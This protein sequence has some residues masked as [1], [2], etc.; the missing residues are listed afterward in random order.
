MGIDAKHR[1]RAENEPVVVPWHSAIDVSQ[2]GWAG[3]RE[4]LQQLSRLGVTKDRLPGPD[5]LQHILPGHALNQLGLPIRFRCSK[6]IPGVSY[7]EHIFA[8]GEVSTR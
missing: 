3:Y 4:P 2:P 1:V 5:Q 7:E 6:S 8:S